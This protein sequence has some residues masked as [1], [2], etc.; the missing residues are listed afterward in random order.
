MERLHFYLENVIGKRINRDIY[1]ENGT[2][3]VPIHTLITYEYIIL[4]EENGVTLTEKDVNSIG[5]YFQAELYQHYQKIEETVKQVSEIFD[6]VRVT[7]KIPLTYLRRDVI[8]MIHEATNEKNLLHLFS[9]LQAKD[10]YTYRHNIAVGVL[11]NLVGKWM[12][13]NHQDLLQLTT[14]ALL[15]DIGKMFIP[16]ELLNKPEKFTN[17]DYAIMQKHTI[18]GF[19]ILK[20][21]TGITYRQAIVALQHHERMDGSGYPLGIKKGQISLFSR[22]VSVVDVFHAMTSNRVYRNASPFYKVLYQMEQ[23]T[24]GVLDPWITRLFIE[25]IMTSLIGFT[26]LLNDGR[27]GTI[28]MVPPHDPSR[29]LIQVEDEFID[30]GKDLSIH[31]EQIIG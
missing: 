26:V 28:L 27:E 4:L 1:S 21:T 9:A 5:P 15:H 2:L 29:P 6:E 14:A 20:E 3:L 22:I 23:D 16:K 25:R 17:E 31:I 7:K 30:L 18:Y 11:A 24:F 13:L 10:D 8:P 12:R 19:E